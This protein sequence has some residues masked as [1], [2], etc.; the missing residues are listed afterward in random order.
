MYIY[1]IKKNQTRVFP[2]G[3]ILRGQR[4]AI[5]EPAPKKPGCI[6]E[7]PMGVEGREKSDLQGQ[8]SL[9]ASNTPSSPGEEALHAFL[10]LVLNSS[11]ALGGKAARTCREPALVSQ[12]GGTQTSADA[13][14]R[15]LG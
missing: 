14:L 10:P 8:S 13:P 2:E 6:W 1:I 4:R 7:R 12:T 11:K 15:L 5:T 3:L 9:A